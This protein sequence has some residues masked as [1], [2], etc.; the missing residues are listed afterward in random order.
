MR[1][2]AL[3]DPSGNRVRVDHALTPDDRPH[4]SLPAPTTHHPVS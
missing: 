2:F 4:D 3:V 1:E